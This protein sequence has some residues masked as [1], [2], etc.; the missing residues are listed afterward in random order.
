MKSTLKLVL[1]IALFLF[2][3]AMPLSKWYESFTTHD[4]R[5]ATVSNIESWQSKTRRGRTVTHR[6]AYYTYE[7]AGVTY[8]GTDHNY[9]PDASVRPGDLLSIHT[10]RA[11]PSRSYIAATDDRSRIVI[12]ALLAASAWLF[13]T[14]YRARRVSPVPY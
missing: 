2:A 12:A 3:L 4:A 9:Q 6:Q 10:A 11:D 1:A 5:Q 14:W 13:F 7:I 8:T